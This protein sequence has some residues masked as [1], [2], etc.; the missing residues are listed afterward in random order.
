[1]Q[2]YSDRI[3]TGFTHK[4]N[5]PYY[6]AKGETWIGGFRVS[7]VFPD[8]IGMAVGFSANV[9]APFDK[10]RATFEKFFHKPLQKCEN[11]EGMRT[12]ELEIADQKTFTLM[13]SDDP[14]GTATLI[15][16]YY[17]YEK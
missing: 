16:C 5:D 15:G 14:K 9:A 2:K 13:S 10:A 4:N 11:G 12:C 17:F 1:M 8:S 7:E 6:T 3:R